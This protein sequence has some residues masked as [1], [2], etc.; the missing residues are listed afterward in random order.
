MP[1]RNEVAAA[2]DSGKNWVYRR[3]TARGTA[4]N[5]L[6]EVHAERRIAREAGDSAALLHVRG[7]VQGVGFRPT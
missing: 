3:G 7:I 5:D 1:R 6:S 2:V 4:V